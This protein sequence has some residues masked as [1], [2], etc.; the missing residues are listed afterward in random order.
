MEHLFSPQPRSRQN[1]AQILSILEGREKEGTEGTR[2]IKPEDLD[3]VLVVQYNSH[4]TL[5]NHLNFLYP[6][7]LSCKTGTTE[8]TSRG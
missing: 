4:V 8:Y 7:H 1:K 2:D 6:S 5:A 3:R